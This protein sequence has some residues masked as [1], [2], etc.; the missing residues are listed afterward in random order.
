MPE[1]R[2]IIGPAELA[3]KID[4]NRGDMGQAEFIEFL[5]NSHFIEKL[6]KTE[7]AGS[8]EYVT[9]EE[10]QS[11]EQDMK[12]LMKNFFDFFVTY[13]LEMGKPSFSKELEELTKKLQAFD[14]ESDISGNRKNATIKWKQS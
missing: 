5:I 10:L 4:A 14:K 2:M 9:V 13:G 1:K 8:T 6:E 12:K 11:F 3:A 7:A